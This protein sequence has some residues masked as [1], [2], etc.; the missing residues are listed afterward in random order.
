[1]HKISWDYWTTIEN[2]YWGETLAVPP[3]DDNDPRP[4]MVTVFDWL[5]GRR[6][7]WF[8]RASESC[9]VVPAPLRDRFED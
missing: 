5:A 4:P 9:P 1:M 3:K 6:T 2:A 7:R 8:G